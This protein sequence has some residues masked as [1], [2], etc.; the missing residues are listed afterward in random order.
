MGGA[1]THV[2]VKS[3]AKEKVNFGTPEDSLPRIVCVS[4]RT[5]A[6]VE[7]LLNPVSDGLMK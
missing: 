2:I 3:F 6:A 7:Q 1:N 4:G 5:E